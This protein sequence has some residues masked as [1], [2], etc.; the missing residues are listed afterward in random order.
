[1]AWQ[2]SDN[3]SCGLVQV[4]EDKEK[5]RERKGESSGGEMGDIGMEGLGRVE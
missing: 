1:M 2:E 4:K 3:A 5:E